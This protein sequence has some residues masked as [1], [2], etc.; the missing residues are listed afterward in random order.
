MNNF[1]KEELKSIHY[2][3]VRN[4]NPWQCGETII[5]KIQSMIDNYCDH[6]F[7]VNGCGENVFGQ[8]HKCGEIRRLMRK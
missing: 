3:L 4:K 8:C 6:E 2:D 7:Y 5:N 1:T